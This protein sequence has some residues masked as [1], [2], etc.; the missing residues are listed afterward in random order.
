MQRYVSLLPV[1]AAPGPEASIKAP[2]SDAPAQINAALAPLSTLC[3]LLLAT[4]QEEVRGV[5]HAVGT[6]LCLRTWVAKGR[7]AVNVLQ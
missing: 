5:G 4:M 3:T 6:V 1:F 2:T 7:A